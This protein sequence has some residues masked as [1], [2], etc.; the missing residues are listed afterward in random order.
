MKKILSLLL[1]TALLNAKVND[2]YFEIHFEGYNEFID[3]QMVTDKTDVFCKVYVYMGDIKVEVNSKKKNKLLE[4]FTKKACLEKVGFIVEATIDDYLL[5]FEYRESK[6]NWRVY[7][8]KTGVSDLNEIWIK[9]EVGKLSVVEKRSI[10]TSRYVYEKE[11]KKIKKI[12][13]S[14]FEGTQSIESEHNIIY[15]EGNLFPTKIVSNYI[16]KLT[17][18][19][20]GKFQRNFEEVVFFRN[21]KNDQNI[22]LKYFTQEN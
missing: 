3:K 16:Q 4:K 7:S 15:E 22:A 1:F 12:N 2:M 11:N 19:D 14:V 10:G 13:T 17:K 20:I 21:F 18:R 8:D 5:N 9:D 6:D